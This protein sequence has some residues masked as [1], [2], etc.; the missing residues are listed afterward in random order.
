M[1]K[2]HRQIIDAFLYPPKERHVALM[3]S[4]REPAAKPIAVPD[5]GAGLTVVGEE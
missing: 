5:E 4:Y 2:T 1:M 3:E